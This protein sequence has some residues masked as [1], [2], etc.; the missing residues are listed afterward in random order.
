MGAITLNDIVITP[1]TK[2]SI[3]GGDVFHAM[4]KSDP[5]YDGYGEAYFSWVNE[6]AIKAW[7]RHKTMTMNLVVPY[8]MVRFVF[9][10]NES[11]IMEENRVI[12]IGTDNYARIT[13]P[14]GVWFG[15]QGLSSPNSLILN[16]SNIIHD[17]NEVERKLLEEIPYNWGPVK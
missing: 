17:Q 6:D 7:K 1:L 16:I 3:S 4:K 8:G 14:H 12:E 10:V 11:K 13:V 15:F 5:G 9:C 2:I